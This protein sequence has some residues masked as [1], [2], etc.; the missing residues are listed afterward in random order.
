M[1]T[2][3]SGFGLSATITASNTFPNGITITAFADDA[4]SMDS[5]D[6]TYADTGSG[7]NGHMVI[8]SKPGGLELAFNVIPTSED[9]VN[10]SA[11]FEANRV[12]LGKSSA[13]DTIGVVV[14]YPDS[15]R[16]TFT[17]GTVLVGSLLPQLASSGRLKSRM[18]RFK[19]ES[20]TKTGATS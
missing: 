20:M 12:G 8:W 1:S 9:D 5:P 13:R 19:F 2:N 3:I 17:N 7:T 11:L 18:Y 6:F 16:A 4:D 15:S 10:L 14:T